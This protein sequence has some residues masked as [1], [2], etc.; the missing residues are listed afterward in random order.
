LKE[1]HEIAIVNKLLNALNLPG[2]GLRRGQPGIEPDVLCLIHNKTI[3]IEVTGAYYRNELAEAEWESA[4]QSVRGE[5]VPA[6]R[7]CDI[8]NGDVLILQSVQ[9]RLSDKCAKKY[10]GTDENWLCIEQRAALADVMETEEM[11]THLEVPAD[12]SFQR[13]F[14]GFH[15][16]VG[17]GGGFRVYSIFPL[18]ESHFRRASA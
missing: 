17:D 6:V 18:R 4:R 14:L 11:I 16:H 1:Q 12:H 2:S 5:S 7:I 10:S 8:D 13:I 9:N 3:G 15:A